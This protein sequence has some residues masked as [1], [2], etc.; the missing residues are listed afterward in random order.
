MRVVYRRA[1]ATGADP[2]KL[3]RDQARWRAAVNA[4]APSRAAVARLYHRRTRAL[5]AQVRRQQ[6]P[7]D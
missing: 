2:R 6:P 7:T 1:L 5:Q 3:A 4:A